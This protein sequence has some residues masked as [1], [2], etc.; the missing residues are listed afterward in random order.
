MVGGNFNATL[1]DYGRLGIVLANDGLRPDDPQQKQIGLGNI[2]WMLQT[3]TGSPRY[4]NRGRQ[5]HIM[6]MATCFGCSLERT[7]G[8]LCLAYMDK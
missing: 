8:L 1:K 7:D 4:F 3:V 5:H 6:D 2:S